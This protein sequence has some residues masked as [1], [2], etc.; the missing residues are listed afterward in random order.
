MKRKIN[1]L[2]AT[3]A[4]CFGLSL[5]AH[6]DDTFKLGFNIS[7]NVS[8]SSSGTFS[9][10][11]VTSGN[12]EVTVDGW[13]CD[14][15][16]ATDQTSS[17]RW[18]NTERGNGYIVQ[19]TDD[20]AGEY[21]YKVTVPEGKKLAV[22]HVLSD[23]FMDD[24]QLSVQVSITQ[25]GTALYTSA[26]STATEWRNT[27]NDNV[28]VTLPAG[29]Y[30]VAAQLSNMTE[31]YNYLGAL[32]L[33]ASLLDATNDP[34]TSL[35]VGETNMLNYISNNV[36]EYNLDYGTTTFPKV[37]AVCKEAYTAEI[38][39]A[40]VS[41]MSASVV[42]KDKSTGDDVA[43]YTINMVPALPPT[44]T[45]YALNTG[46]M[47][48][49]DTEQKFVMT[50]NTGFTVANTGSYGSTFKIGNGGTYTITVP[51]DVSIGLMKVIGDQAMY[52]KVVGLDTICTE[53]SSKAHTMFISNHKAGDPISMKNDL[54]GNAWVQFELST[55]DFQNVATP[56][57]TLNALDNGAEV[58][59][60]CATEN[61]E[62]YYTTDGTEPSAASTRYEGKF[63]KLSNGT[64][65]AIA[66]APMFYLHNSEVVEA[67]VTD[68]KIK[69]GYSF[70]F[71]P[72]DYTLYNDKD[73]YAYL[74]ESKKNPAFKMGSASDMY[75]DGRFKFGSNEVAVVVPT[76]AIVTKLT[77][78]G[79]GEL[80]GGTIT[81]DHVS[82]T[83]T[84]S[85][86]YTTEISNG[87]N[88]EIILTGH[89]MG[90]PIAFQISGG[91]PAFS[92]LTVEYNI[93]NDGTVNYSG[94]DS[95]GQEKNI[96][97]CVQ[98]NFDREVSLVDGKTANID[99]KD[100]FRTIGRSSS[101]ESYYWDLDYSSSHTLTLPAGSVQDVWGNVYDKDIKVTF[102]TKVAPDAAEAY[103]Y[104]YVVGN[105]D[106]LKA[107]LA[108]V[109]ATNTTADAP[110][111]R[112]FLKNGIYLL[113]EEGVPADGTSDDRQT[114]IDGYNISIIG[115]SKDG[116]IIRSYGHLG[117][118]SR[119][120][121]LQN[122]ATNVYLQDLTITNASALES[123]N[124]R[125]VMPAYAGGTKTILKNV[126]LVSGQDTYVSGDRVYMEDCDIHGTVDFI[127]GGGENLFYRSNLY[128]EGGGCVTAPL[129]GSDND[130][131]YVFMDCTIKPGT[132]AEST[133]DKSYTLGRPW[134][135]DNP[136]AYYL[137]TCM[138]VLPADNGWG[139]MSLCHT[140]FYEYKSTDKDGALLDL[141]ARTVE[142]ISQNIYTPVL[143]DDRAAS[144]N[145]RNIL[146]GKDGW[147]PSTYT[148]Q[149][150][151]VSIA[152]S[153]NVLEWKQGDGALSYVVFKDGVYVANTKD[154]M[155][156]MSE[157]GLY[158]VRAANEMGGLGEES[159]A[160]D[161]QAAPRF[162]I[163][164]AGCA[165]L[166]TPA[167]KTVTFPADV[168]VWKATKTD[169]STVTMTQLLGIIPAATPLLVTGK[170]GNYELTTT[171]ETATAD[172]TGNM[173][174]GFAVDTEITADDM[175]SY[176]Y[177]SL[178][179][180]AG[181]TSGF[182]KRTKA[183]TAKAGKAYLRI[184]GATETNTAKFSVYFDD[185]STG[186]SGVEANKSA[187]G[188]YYNL[189]GQRISAPAKGLYILNGKKYVNK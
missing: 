71:E 61:A 62:I 82:S 7:S 144:F 173:F 152:V 51:S 96:A 47:P 137:N 172:V 108:A 146:G 5:S 159:N 94:S 56:E 42:V 184:D 80:Y 55:L 125:G 168:K 131:G 170:E 4:A 19:D 90:T 178:N 98:L 37:S 15:F 63:V 33:T 113:T 30:T 73:G 111:K 52:E 105:A 121:T 79:L 147:E 165:T 76:N 75:S 67:S 124:F 36:A 141:S 85:I 128:I 93:Y 74:R 181:S 95:E 180:P 65:R 106:E 188:V 40:S 122:N 135:G 20:N 2:L 177:Y 12:S 1:I 126:N 3:L 149:V 183:F 91:N 143:A 189:N 58:T 64:I 171:A 110:R 129:H 115:Q 176:T 83:G 48:W 87:A 41:T 112:I 154:C 72:G 130:Y 77:F 116:V 53:L 174:V 102:T 142:G 140:S 32:E 13:F 153:E 46:T 44:V 117:W 66:V 27:L 138:E 166:V 134:K 97:G 86:D 136:S 163:S 99:G 57:I 24:N 156:S 157:S 182:Y 175:A 92:K 35:T 54:W 167:D 25:D 17:I 187:N 16:T 84:T 26:V 139:G 28:T 81:W 120:T 101:I 123:G 10:W 109:K 162:S 39:Q 145:E 70:S 11:S 78:E 29:T 68:S 186:I 18:W 158:T 160:I 21:G 164:A 9:E 155:F 151:A 179:A 43:T 60:S 31:R 107:A 118:F 103:E 88:A 148:K 119:S 45:T 22:S 185:A 100:V 6:A 161:Y 133:A 59:I 8:S 127:C 14:G 50:S 49:S 114:T 38:T 34:L 104:D 69:D 23:V 169:G 132:Y 150:D 89:K